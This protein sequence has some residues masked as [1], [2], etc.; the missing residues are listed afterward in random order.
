MITAWRLCNNQFA[1]PAG[2]GAKLYVGRWNPIGY[3]VV[4]SSECLPLAKLEALVHTHRRPS[5]QVYIQIA[6]EEALVME[7]EALY[8]LPT[9]WN[10]DEPS[11]QEIGARWVDAGS[12]AVLSVPSVVVSIARNYL[13]NPMHPLFPAVS[14]SATTPYTFDDRLI[15]PVPAGA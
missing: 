5:D 10:Q 14:C 2:E 8:S 13:L 3:A 11:T 6:F 1:E 9:G 15:N 7:V 4:Y 12:S